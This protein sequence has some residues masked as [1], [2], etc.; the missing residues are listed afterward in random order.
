MNVAEKILLQNDELK[1]VMFD[2][3]ELTGT[4][5]YKLI[6]FWTLNEIIDYT[7][8]KN[9]QIKKHKQLSNNGKRN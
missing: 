6:D 2:I 8:R 4:G 9:E 7:K 1:Q 3:A 5:N